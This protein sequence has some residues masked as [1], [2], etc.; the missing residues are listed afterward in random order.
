MSKA[1][2]A[3]HSGRGDADAPASDGPRRSAVPL[4]LMMAG[5]VVLAV[6]GTT[7]V[8]LMTRG[9]SRHDGTA[10]ATAES[11]ST[12]SASAT[13]SVRP[14]GPV[15][16]KS[17]PVSLRIRRLGV[18]SPLVPLGLRADGTIGLPPASHVS[19]AGWYE[20]SPTPGQM[21]PSILLGYA[22][23]PPGVE[24]P[25]FGRL[26]RLHR[27]DVIQVN[28]ADGTAAVFRVSRV[29]RYPVTRFP[30]DEV[31]SKTNY[32]ALRLITVALPGSTPAPTDRNIVVYANLVKR[33]AAS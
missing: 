20:N 17:T 2:R 28:R 1:R 27:G 4:R 10:Q 16:A 8:G 21:G 33:A 24:H 26:D 11:R 7:A 25:V 6:A 19:S 5:A 31:Y 18:R 32:A 22:A 30:T 9:H 29:G 13:P 15:M 12:G 3:K 14:R 23:A